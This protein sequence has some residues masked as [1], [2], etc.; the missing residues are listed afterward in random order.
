MTPS[1]RSVSPPNVLKASA[2]RKHLENQKMPAMSYSF[3]RLL[4][5]GY[6]TL[7]RDPDLDLCFYFSIPGLI[8]S[9]A[10][11]RVFGSAPFILLGTM[12]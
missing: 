2:A 8:I 11:L 3:F 5:C 10:F 12:S 6:A 1:P 7:Q 9:L 4:F